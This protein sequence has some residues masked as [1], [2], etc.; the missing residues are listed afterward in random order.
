MKMVQLK[1]I[2]RRKERPEW[3]NNQK[4]KETKK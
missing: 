2:Q 3:D 4:Y 1:D